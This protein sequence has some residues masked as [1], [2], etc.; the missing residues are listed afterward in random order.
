M[1]F[2]QTCK[3]FFF[4]CPMGKW[5][6]FRFVSPCCHCYLTFHLMKM[7]LLKYLAKCI[8]WPKNSKSLLPSSTA[9]FDLN[10]ILNK[11]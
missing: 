5:I 7:S 9:Q 2:C 10:Y 4:T 8:K 1:F 11:K 3:F 6:F